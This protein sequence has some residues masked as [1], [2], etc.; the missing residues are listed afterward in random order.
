MAWPQLVTLLCQFVVGMTD[1]WAAGQLGFEVQASLGLITQCQMLLMVLCMATAS[2][3][4]AAVSQSLGAG[5]HDRAR[6]YVGLL[7]TV[8]LGM[9]VVVAL[10]AFG[11]RG[12][13]L[14]LLQTPEAI[15][16]VAILFFNVTMCTMPGHYGMTISSAMFRSAKSV[17][18]PLYVALGVVAIN[19]VGDL[20]FGLGWWGLP[21][22]GAAGIAWSTFVSATAGAI[23]L[24][25]LLHHE[26]LLTRVS[27]PRLR[28]VRRGAPYLFK[29]ALPALATS[30]LWQ[31]GY[32]VL[33]IITASLPA[34]SVYALAGLTAGLRV[35]AFLF[36]PAVAFNMTAGVLVGHCLGED[37]RDEARRVAMTILVAGCCLMSLVGAVVWPFRE[38]LAAFITPDADVQRQAVV[39][40]TY[41]ILSVPFTVASVILTGV[42]NGAGATVY[43]MRAISLSIWM[44]RLPLAWVFGHVVWKDSSGVFMA[45]LVSQVVQASVLLFVLLKS[46]WSRFVMRRASGGES[47]HQS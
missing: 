19:V 5:R 42:F 26:G 21:A 22:F 36:L 46:D 43:P 6:R 39:Y 17:L 8:A 30:A 7:C 40:L 31:T 23:T 3:A 14:R 45:M 37:D 15:M 4:V 20:G 18:K 13:F 41:N 25:L 11:F 2:G 24:L 35:E 28:W 33:F 38:A 34:E 16:P 27:I 32:L 44:I 29:V 10:V 9:G 47:S 12:P 1:V